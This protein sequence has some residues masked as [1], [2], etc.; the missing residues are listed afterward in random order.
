[1]SRS[2]LLLTL[3]QVLVL[4]EP[5][6]ARPANKATIAPETLTC[7]SNERADVKCQNLRFSG[8][9]YRFPVAE[10][11]VKFFGEPTRALE[12]SVP[13]SFWTKIFHRV[14]PKRWP[15]WML[16]LPSQGSGSLYI[17]LPDDLFQW[18]DTPGWPKPPV[19]GPLVELKRVDN[20]VLWR[21]Q[22]SDIPKD[23]LYI[24]FRDRSDIYAQCNDVTFNKAS[25]YCDVNWFDGSALHMLGVPADWLRNAPDFVDA[26]RKAI[27]PE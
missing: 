13:D 20:L 22:A 21:S 8:K 27:R 5:S 15:S 19:R 1:M 9:L 17:T 18:S 25:H 3:L 10:N 24:T 7:E 16:N 4:T 14:D 12:I 11:L 23:Y 2:L 6:F 26:Y